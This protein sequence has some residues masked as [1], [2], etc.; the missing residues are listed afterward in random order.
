MIG[1]KQ[2]EVKEKGSKASRKDKMHFEEE[3]K[4]TRKAGSRWLH[5]L[6]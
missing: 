1:K 5:V 4:K 6:V 2:F 3:E